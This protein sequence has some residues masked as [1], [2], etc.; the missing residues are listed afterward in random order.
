MICVSI[1][2]ETNAAAQEA[3]RAA[4]DAGDIAEW[5]LDYLEEPPDLERVL[6]RKPCPVICTNRPVREGGRAVGSEARRIETLR[7][8][9]ACGADYVDIELDSAHLLPD[10]GPARRIVSYH[11][12]AETP[13]NLPEV[14]A[15]IKAAGADIAKLATYANSLS[16]NARMLELV[17]GADPP[18]IGVCMGE[19][20]QASR[21]LTCRFG[22][23]LTFASLAPGAE[24]APGQVPAEEMRRFYR[25]PEHTPHTAIYGVI[26]DPIGHSMS[27]AIFNEAFKALGIDAVYLAFRVTDVADFIDL[28]KRLGMRGCSVT[29]PHKQTILP[30]MDE[31]D[32]L[33]RRIGA[34][35][36]VAVRDGRLF[37]TN[38]DLLAALSGIEEALARGGSEGLEGKSALLIGA[39]GAG[40]AIAFGLVD[41]GARLTIAN[42]TRAKADALAEELGCESIPLEDIRNWRGDVLVNATSVGMH[43]R[44]DASPA[45]AEMIRPGMVV[46]DAV[47]N[48]METKLLREAAARGAATVS[49]FDMFVKQAAAQFELWF[50]RPAPAEVMARVVGERLRRAGR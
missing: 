15:R 28:F 41:R 25:V 10:A 35:N 3:L 26:G 21:I 5:R 6:A 17:R 36:T 38:T 31:V 8:A 14:L 32:D 13:E 22:G 40:R 48:P 18:V 7:Q 1:T 33:V 2:A 12:F 23:F 46:F 16:D 30:F 47:Y 24:S 20:G 42:R 34:M 39:G 43:P 29:I 44:E 37:G 9:A 11:N 27:P 49:G 45:P 50:D 19:L 4:A